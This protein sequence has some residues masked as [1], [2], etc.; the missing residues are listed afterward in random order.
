M[1]K[2]IVILISSILAQLV[3]YEELFH[4]QYIDIENLT[5][6]VIMIVINIFTIINRLM[7]KQLISKE[8]IN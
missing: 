4:S 3:I 8:E 2:A 1:I 6:A 5:L 7:F